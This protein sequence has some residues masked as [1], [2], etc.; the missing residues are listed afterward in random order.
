[1]SLINMKQH[2]FYV[3]SNAERRWKDTPGRAYP[4]NTWH[5][6]DAGLM[7]DHRLRRW[8]NI[9]PALGEVR[10]RYHDSTEVPTPATPAT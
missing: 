5:S 1:M 3:H 6:P 10:A 8:A 4:A 7:L 2:L 9:K